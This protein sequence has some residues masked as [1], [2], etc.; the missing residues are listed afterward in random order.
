MLC[1]QVVASFWVSH[2][3]GPCCMASENRPGF[4]QSLR[5][6]QP[7]GVKEQ[8]QKRSAHSFQGK[9]RAEIRWTLTSW[10][11]WL[12]ILV[13]EVPGSTPLLAEKMGCLRL[14]Q[15]SEWMRLPFIYTAF[16]C[17]LL[18][19]DSPGCTRAGGKWIML[20]NILNQ[21]LNLVILSVSLSIFTSLG[22]MWRQNIQNLLSTSTT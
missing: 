10:E 22:S 13:C 3:G 6:K 4:H 17:C 12:S 19:T 11:I 1:Y 8:Q 21:D 7:L 20:L 18:Y 15:A 16:L 2:Q 5:G 9:A 14:P